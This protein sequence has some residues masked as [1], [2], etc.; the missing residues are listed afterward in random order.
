M[1]ERCKFCPGG[2]MRP[3]RVETN[4]GQF[5]DILVCSWCGAAEPV[6]EPRLK[7]RPDPR[8]ARLEVFA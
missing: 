2:T 8:V 3:D 5:E 4:P 1:A 6:R 7:V